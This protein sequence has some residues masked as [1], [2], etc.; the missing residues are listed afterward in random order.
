MSWLR[1]IGVPC[2]WL[3]GHKWRYRTC[4]WA[5]LTYQSA[6]ELLEQGKVREAYCT[7]CPATRPV[8]AKVKKEN[9]I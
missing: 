6:K 7:R 2:A 8:R 4:K 1:R 9:V 5:D 3:G